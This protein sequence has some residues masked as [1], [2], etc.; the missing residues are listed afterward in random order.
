MKAAGSERDDATAARFLCPNE[1]TDRRTMLMMLWP[2]NFDL[3]STPPPH[4]PGRMKQQPSARLCLDSP[5][6]CSAILAKQAVFSHVCVSPSL[7]SDT[8]SS[9]PTLPSSPPLA[10]RGPPLCASLRSNPSVSQ[11]VE[12]RHNAAAPAVITRC[13]RGT[14]VTSLSPAKSLRQ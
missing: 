12:N 11:P 13:S 4:T 3:T 14:S 8:R 1:G 5:T 10:R 2:Q 7:L 9:P 6:P